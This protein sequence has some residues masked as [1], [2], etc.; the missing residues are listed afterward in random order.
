MSFLTTDEAAR[1]LGVTPRRIV[2]LLNQRL[3]DG[4]QVQRDWM[5]SA[6][7][8]RQREAL[9]TARGRPLTPQTARALIE[10]LNNGT[11]LPARRG[12]L[13]RSRN[14]ELLSSAIA[15]T[16][17][18]ETFM[19]RDPQLVLERL[20]LTAESALQRLT[21]GVGESLAGQPQ[22]IHGYPRDASMEELIDDAMLVRSD[23]GTVHVYQ[24][25]DGLFPWEETPTALIAV[26]SARSASSRVRAAGIDAF[27]TKRTEWLAKHTL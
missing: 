6:A 10:A 19:T 9:T 3:L 2:Q 23:E 16:V 14:A 12:S 13:L 22:E 18:I 24:F 15:H 17:S 4:R 11:S 5:V 25:R 26:D 27:E 7:S 21:T 8:V 20:N 1:R